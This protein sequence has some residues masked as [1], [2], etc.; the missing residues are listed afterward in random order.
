MGP[1]PPYLPLRAAAVLL[2]CGEHF[3]R[4]M[5][6]IFFNDFLGLLRFSLNRFSLNR[7]RKPL[8]ILKVFSV[9]QALVV[10]V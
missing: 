10:T 3:F 1:G 8:I 9:H 2:R 6:M 7:N 5:F 4:T